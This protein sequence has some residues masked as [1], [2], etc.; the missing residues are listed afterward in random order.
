VKIKDFNSYSKYYSND[1]KTFEKRVAFASPNG[2]VLEIFDSITNVFETNNISKDVPL[3]IWDNFSFVSNTINEGFNS[4]VFNHRALPNISEMT[5][6]FSGKSFIPKSVT[7]R[8]LVKKMKFPI[9]A[10]HGSHQEEFK[11]F[12]KFKKSNT[13][14]ESFQEKPIASARFEVLAFNNKPLHIEK[15]INQFPFDVDISRFNHLAQVK[16]ICEAINSK[17]EPQFYIISLIE[18]NNNLFLESI[19]RSS[20]LSPVQSVKMYE[21]AYTD[22]Y[23]S[24][25]P[26]WYKNKLMNEHVAPYYKKKYYDSLLIK[27]AGVID[28]SKYVK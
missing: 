11:T 13:K 15:K 9:I 16:D 2:N 20:K 17:Y 18:K 21:A 10:K 7:D 28:Y 25:L 5:D 19:T 14:F 6:H 4:F 24:P 22:Y 26:S 8:S 1:Y 23:K 27:P 12:G 3:I